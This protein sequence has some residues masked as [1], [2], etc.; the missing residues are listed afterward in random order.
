MTRTTIAR[1]VLGALLASAAA[2]AG[3]AQPDLVPTTLSSARLPGDADMDRTPAQFAWAVSDAADGAAPYLDES[4]EF[5]TEVGADTLAKGWRAP[6]T[7]PGAVVRITPLPADLGAKAL[8]A[9]IA[10]ESLEFRTASGKLAA[11]D[12]VAN[13]ADA[14]QLRDAGMPM[15]DGSV[16]F[17]LR[18]ELGANVTIALAQPPA[19]RFLV[20]VF[21]PASREVLSLGATR[22]TVLAGQ[23][24]EAD[25][26]LD[27]AQ[28]KSLG[29]VSGMLVAPDGSSQPVSFAKA[30]SGNARTVVVPRGAAGMPGLWE[31]HAFATSSDGTVQRDAKTAFAVAVPRA[32]TNGATRTT[33]TREGVRVDVAVNVAAASRYDASA[34]LYAT[35]ADGR[36]VPAAIAHSAAWLEP[37]SRTLTLSF[38]MALLAERGLHAPFVLRTLTLTD[39]SQ[40]AIVEQRANPR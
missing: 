19:P 16:A 8:T 11:L 20:H 23:A 22:S 21:E 36:S 30:G 38:P 34:M 40:Q 7:A 27:S 32:R 4:R 1:A 29:R 5:S 37:G 33:S 2:F 9:P 31:L 24:L 26:G 3:A 18:P 10:F 28:G 39:Q 15:P 17:K 14:A 35:D 12:A 25:V 13:H 6:F